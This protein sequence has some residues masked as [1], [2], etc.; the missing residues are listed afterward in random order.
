M[1]PFAAEGGE[2]TLAT[3]FSSMPNLDIL[4]RRFAC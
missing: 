1:D 2:D 3:L 4:L